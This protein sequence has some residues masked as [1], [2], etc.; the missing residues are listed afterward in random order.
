[1]QAHTDWLTRFKVDPVRALAELREEHPLASGGWGWEPARRV[2]TLRYRHDDGHPDIERGTTPEE[3]KTKRKRKERDRMLAASVTG[4]GTVGSLLE[5]WLTDVIRGKADGTVDNYRRS[6]RYITGQIDPLTPV[7]SLTP[8]MVTVMFAELAEPGRTTGPCRNG[9]RSRTR[10]ALGKRSL[11]VVK[12]HLNMA[13]DFGVE[14]DLIPA[15]VR[16]KLKAYKVPVVA[17]PAKPE[18]FDLADYDKM[19]AYLAGHLDVRNAVFVVMLL[20][21]LRVGEALGLR[22]KY[23]DLER[24]VLRVE[25][26]MV[27]AGSRRGGWTTVLKTDHA[28]NFAHRAVPIPGLALTVLEWLKATRVESPGVVQDNRGRD[29]SVDEFVFVERSGDCSGGVVP[30]SA[31]NRHTLRLAAEVGV[32]ALCPKGYRHTFA[33]VCIHNGMVYELL[34]KLMGHQDTTQIIQTYGHPMIDPATID[35]ERYLGGAADRRL[36]AVV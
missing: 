34:A 18:W 17:K 23:V 24:G 15:D 16:I 32:K 27:R 13:L 20:C 33:S 3:C 2:I 6:V 29:I 22:W 4:D 25:G 8:T 35:L 5:R 28:H 11:H 12:T 9:R 10:R 14:N 7:I 36:A 1:M 26:Q 21:G 31:I 19:T 30:A